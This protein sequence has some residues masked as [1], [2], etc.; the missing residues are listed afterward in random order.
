MN[1]ATAL[2]KIGG[3]GAVESL[4]AFLKDSDERVRTAAAKAIEKLGAT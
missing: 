4:Q 2:G 3:A 1:A